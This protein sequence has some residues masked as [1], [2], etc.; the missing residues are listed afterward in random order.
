[1]GWW[2][3]TIMGGD[4]PLDAQ[5]DMFDACGVTS[6]MFYPDDDA[7]LISIIDINEQIKLNVAAMTE[8]AL[9]DPD[10][11]YPGV[12]R[13]VLGVMVMSAG[14]DPED[15]D[16]KRALQVAREGAEADEWDD[17]ERRA[18]VA[19]FI[20]M[21]DNY[22]GT[23]QEPKSEGVFE[24]IHEAIVEGKSGLINKQPT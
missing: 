23:P 16:V 21:I 4:T 17:D 10:S 15:E 18:Y 3:C 22:D 14:C 12:Y 24:K 6:D 7:D 8:V 2:S 9:N 11:W 1:M 19:N 5:G 20:E 13:Q